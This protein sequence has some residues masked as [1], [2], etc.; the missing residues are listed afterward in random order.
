MQ[1]QQNYDLHPYNSDNLLN[2]VRNTQ[3]NWYNLSYNRKSN[4][5]NKNYSQPLL[6]S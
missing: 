1:G 6:V 4:A 5:N 3:R 2:Y